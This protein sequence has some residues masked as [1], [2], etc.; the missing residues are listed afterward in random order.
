MNFCSRIHIV[1]QLIRKYPE[2]VKLENYLAL[3]Q[4]LSTL[5]IESNDYNAVYN[6]YESFSTMIDRQQL[7]DMQQTET[8]EIWKSIGD[9][10]VR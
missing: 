3:L 7:I 4:I 9:T 2:I 1:W 6:I 5:Q 8:I 10:T